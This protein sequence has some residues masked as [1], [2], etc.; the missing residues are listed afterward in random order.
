MVLF[1]CESA[2]SIGSLH[3]RKGKAPLATIN[4]EHRHW[5]R[6][7]KRKEKKRKRIHVN[8]SF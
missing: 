1:I 5:D 7:E 2:N 6:T 8:S 3:T 4:M